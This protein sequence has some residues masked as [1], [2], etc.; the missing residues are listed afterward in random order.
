MLRK[1]RGF[2]PAIAAG[3][4][5]KG[6]RQSARSRGIIPVIPHK[7]NDKHK[8]G[9]FA[10]TI[11]KGRVRIEQA[12]GKLKRFKHIALLSPQALSK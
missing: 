10:R 9:F 3:Y 4:A 11:C 6:N 8:P 5:S 1:E 12:V 2:D 7:A